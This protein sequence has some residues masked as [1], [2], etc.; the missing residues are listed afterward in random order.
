MKIEQKFSNMKCPNCGLDPYSNGMKI[1]LNWG[2]RRVYV[3][4]CLDPYS[5]GMKIEPVIPR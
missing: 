3:L 2:E 5:N 1:E 4:N